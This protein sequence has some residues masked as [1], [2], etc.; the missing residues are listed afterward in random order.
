MPSGVETACFHAGSAGF[1]ESGRSS[2]L[3]RP[4]GRAGKA[5]PVMRVPR[6]VRTWA[7]AL[8]ST[9]LF[10]MI[11]CRA[12]EPET[13]I[14]NHAPETYV[15]G[16]PQVG[17]GGQFHHH[18]FW[19][20]SD[21]DG[22]VVR[23]IW[24]LTEGTI[25]NPNT[26]DD[27]EDIRFNPAES[28]T[29][30]QIG[31]YTTRTDSVFD[32]RIN[33]GCVHVGGPDVSHRGRGRPGRLRPHAGPLVFPEQRPR[34]AHHRVLPRRRAERGDGLRRFRHD[35]LRT[36]LPLHLARDD[37]EHPFLQCPAT[38]GTRHRAAAGRAV[39]VQVPHAAGR[40]PATRRATTAGTRV[41]STRSRTGSFP[42]S[43]RSTASI[44]ATTTSGEDVSQRR[45]VQGVH[46]LLV[47]TVDVAGVE[48]QADRRIS[49][50]CS[51]STPRR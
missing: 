35:R 47:N 13:V 41:A 20:G 16:G 22:R 21:S 34:A 48:I 6:H 26:D 46:S 37:A 43:P 9:A 18:L 12:F 4:T 17:E 44:S 50:S 8:L 51:I 15:T 1:I 5:I 30:L 28:I 40:A 14:V 11:G 33:E 27:E 42:T 23:Y 19:Y 10:A 36:A 38:R 31:H 2:V 29:T 25:Q 24:A 32:F 49:T 45:L 7:S 39:R 3:A